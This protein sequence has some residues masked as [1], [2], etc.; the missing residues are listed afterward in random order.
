[1]RLSAAVSAVVATFRRRPADLLPF[2][3]L[4]ASVAAI[5]RVVPFFALVVAY[6]FLEFTGRLEALRAEL[7]TL[8]QPPADPEAEP[9]AFADWLE[10][11]GA[12]LEATV[13]SADVVLVMSG[14]FL[15]ALTVSVLLGVLLSA[16]VAAGQIATCHA[17]LRDERGLTAGID[18]VRRYWLSFLGLFVLEL[19]LWLA[20]GTLV[21]TIT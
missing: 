12:V 3:V 10:E 7:V 5:V 2:Y 16:V 19:L 21:A 13:V 1:M 9:E 17:R 14:L 20:A 8:E 4:G 6:L 15:I 18:G 11:L